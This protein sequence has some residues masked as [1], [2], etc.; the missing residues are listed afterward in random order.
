MMLPLLPECLGVCRSLCAP[1]DVTIR[2]KKAT[3]VDWK[4][5]QSVS[6]GMCDATMYV[7]TTV[8]SRRLRI[9]GTR[10]DTTL[11]T[12]NLPCRRSLSDLASR[13]QSLLPC[14]WH[15]SIPGSG[16]EEVIRRGFEGS[17]PDVLK[18]ENTHLCECHSHGLLHSSGMPLLRSS[19]WKTGQRVCWKVNWKVK[20]DA[21]DD[22]QLRNQFS[23]FSTLERRLKYMVFYCTCTLYRRSALHSSVEMSRTRVLSLTK[24]R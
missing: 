16:S 1:T 6:V 9:E 4:H 19:L 15:L 5:L 10:A 17:T 22:P 18:K 8:R 12:L 11:P 7:Y 3:E 13:W 23:L 14:R 21:T 20:L 2:G 24:Y